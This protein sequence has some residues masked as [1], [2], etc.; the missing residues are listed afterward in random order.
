MSSVSL[1]LMASKGTL[2]YFVHGYL[3]CIALR[4][5]SNYI[6]WLYQVSKYWENAIQCR[7]QVYKWLGH[8]IALERKEYLFT[9]FENIVFNA[10]MFLLCNHGVKTVFSDQN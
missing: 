7:K 1:S 5:P 3:L 9:F 6:G 4:F 10:N 2:P 8:N